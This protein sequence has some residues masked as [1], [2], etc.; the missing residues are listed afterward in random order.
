MSD[1]PTSPS[2]TAEAERFAQ[3]F[4]QLRDQVSRVIVG[5]EQVVDELVIAIA[6]RGHAI[7]VGVPGL[8]KTL[9]VSTL[10]R[11]LEL[12]FHRIQFTP[13][14][15]PGDITG[16]EVLH[17]DAATKTWVRYGKGFT[18]TPAVAHA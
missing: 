5:Q 10:S 14:L 18:R 13:D 8:A 12:D 9:L 7:L 17:T 6:A 11:T 16:A 15:M 4:S 1:I 3:A 2:D